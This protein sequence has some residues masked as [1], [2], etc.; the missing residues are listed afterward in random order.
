MLYL[1]AAWFRRF[2]HELAMAIP[3]K[4]AQDRCND[5]ITSFG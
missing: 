2:P 3:P 5:V 4:R 1:I